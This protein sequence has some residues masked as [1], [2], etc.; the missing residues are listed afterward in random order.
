[1]KEEK[2]KSRTQEHQVKYKWKSL[3]EYNSTGKDNIFYI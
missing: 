1:M 2:I 3:D